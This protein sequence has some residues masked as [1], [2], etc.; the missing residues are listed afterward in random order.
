LNAFTTLA[1]GRELLDLFAG[2]GRVTDGQAHVVGGEGVGDVDDRLAGDVAGGGERRGRGVE[3][4][5]E[6]DHLG[7]LGRGGDGFAARAVARGG[8][9]SL[10][11]GK[12]ARADDDLVTRLGEQSGQTLGHG[13]GAENCDGHMKLSRLAADIGCL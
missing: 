13:A 2:A 8:G 6:D 7:R 10:S 9:H 3:G 5:G 11:L 12:V 4:H 1:F